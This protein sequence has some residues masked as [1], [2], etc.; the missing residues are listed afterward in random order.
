MPTVGVCTLIAWKV[1]RMKR[2]QVESRLAV[3]DFGS[4][5]FGEQVIPALKPEVIEALTV[6]ICGCTPT[7]NASPKETIRGTGLN[8]TWRGVEKSK[9][10]DRWESYLWLFANQA[11]NLAEASKATCKI[12]VPEIYKDGL[13]QFLKEF[14]KRKTPAPATKA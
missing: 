7:L 6:H 13:A 5:K 12:G 10:P 9:L 4:I 1:N 2:E 14:E 3:V 11:Y 8:V